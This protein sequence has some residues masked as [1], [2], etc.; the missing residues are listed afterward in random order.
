MEN[1]IWKYTIS[2]QNAKL[3]IIAV[4]IRVTVLTEPELCVLVLD[5][6]DGHLLSLIFWWRK[7]KGF[8]HTK[9]QENTTLWS[10]HYC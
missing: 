7:K 4:I 9:L 6:S 8:V 3:G 2:T 5:S 10:R 1:S